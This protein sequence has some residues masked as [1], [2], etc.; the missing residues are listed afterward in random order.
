M[1]DRINA[2]DEIKGIL[3]ES[4]SCPLINHSK[5]SKLNKNL[6]YVTY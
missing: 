3:N 4:Y 6:L 2:I 1:N 5:I